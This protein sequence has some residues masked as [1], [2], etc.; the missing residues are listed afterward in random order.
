M[1]QG[2]SKTCAIVTSWRMGMKK[3]FVYLFGII[4]SIPMLIS[5]VS[6]GRYGG[7]SPL[8]ERCLIELDDSLSITGIKGKEDIMWIGDFF[9]NIGKTVV[10][11][12][13]G[14]QSLGF[15]YNSRE[16]TFRSQYHDEWIEYKSNTEIKFDFKSGHH[17]KINAYRKEKYIELEVIDL[18]N[19][20]ALFHNGVYT[21]GVGSFGVHLGSG[22]FSYVTFGLDFGYKF[23]FDIGTPII[24]SLNA[25]GDMG[26]GP[27][28]IEDSHNEY[29]YYGRVK[30]VTYDTSPISVPFGGYG[31]IFGHFFV[32][33]TDISIG[34]GYGYRG[35][36]NIPSVDLF[37]SP[38]IR[39]EV[40]YKSFGIYFEYYTDET[41]SYR[42]ITETP[43]FYKKWG[44]GIFGRM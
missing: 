15:K 26:V 21:G 19:N 34:G 10:S 23:I 36:L 41:V 6:Y 18:G 2:V 39:G 27:S 37:Y 7:K 25:G 12:P 43:N 35:E 20:T 42:I 24:L 32:P 28:V 3:S 38:F 11:I 16:Y 17:Y 9:E 14:V 44:V 1:A 22:G 33:R 30:N 29:D 5:C 31:G 40:L 8:K 13:S 4:V